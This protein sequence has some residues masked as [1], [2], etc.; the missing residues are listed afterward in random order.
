MGMHYTGF[1]GPY[2]RCGVLTHPST[3]EIKVCSKRGCRFAKKS[4]PM[5]D[6]NNFCPQCGSAA[7]T[8]EVKDKGQIVDV[9]DIYDV[10]MATDERLTEFNSEYGQEGIHLFVSNHI[11]SLGIE[12]SRDA[13]CGEIKQYNGVDIDQE[14]MAFRDRHER[15]LD[16]LHEHYG[17]DRV[18]V[19]WGLIGEI[20]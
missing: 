13:R 18:E 7:K 10:M 1:L 6:A 9:V 14:L 5:D 3:K 16:I 17:E 11:K 15:D 4:N 20:S 8:K 2:V 12:I 19:C